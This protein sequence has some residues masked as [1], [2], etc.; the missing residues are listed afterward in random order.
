MTRFARAKGSKASNERVPEEATSWQTM[1]EQLEEKKREAI[2]SKKRKEFEDKR[3]ENYKNFLEEKENSVK[4]EWAEIGGPSVTDV[5]APKELKK[6]KK[7][8]ISEGSEDF[9]DDPTLHALITKIEKVLENEEK[10][11]TP[12]KKKKKEIHLQYDKMNGRNE[13]IPEE[14]MEVSSDTKAKKSK[15]KNEQIQGSLELK[16]PNES[17]FD[18]DAPEETSAKVMPIVVNVK[19]KAKLSKKEPLKIPSVNKTDESITL[20][21]VG[22]QNES[23]EENKDKKSSK[24][25][26]K[27]KK[28][29][30][31]NNNPNNIPKPKKPIG[32]LTED[33][34]KRINKK[35][36]KRLRQRANRKMRKALEEEA[37]AA[38]E[39]Q[40]QAKN[41]EKRKLPKVRD[42]EEHK[43]RKPDEKVQTMYINGVD[44]EIDYYDGFP[45]KREDAER[46][47]QLRK[48]MI[49]K[50][51]PKS[52]VQISL[53][54]E[55][56]KA[57]K[58]LAREKKKVCFNCRKS[59]HNL[60]ECPNLNENMQQEMIGTGI[61]FKCGSTEHTHYECKVVRTDSYKHAT[62]FICHKQGHISRQCPDNQKGLYPKGGACRIC[63]D[64][65]HLKK[66]CPKFQVEQESKTIKLDTLDSSNIEGLED[67]KQTKL[68]HGS[69][70]PDKI[71]KF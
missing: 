44:V 38:A 58:A 23:K 15:N 63:G 51:I 35:N 17:N 42:N 12:K 28:E 60:S 14:N 26:K 27:K 64:V 34:I 50:G 2:E 66:D 69:T 32:E 7:R 41:S 24:Q 5:K 67:E 55:R 6:K 22:I 45:I 31:L 19:R 54:L 20:Q 62:C 71:V 9:E 33:Q 48:D 47:R 65:T 18:K 21:D 56:R 43:R 53:K 8:K 52:E 16:E 37:K 46:L 40:V 1:K 11:Q 70:K 30:K 10:D 57:E 4:S 13:E 25:D 29:V 61:C 68:K 36:A 3:K 59:G 39:Q 49:S